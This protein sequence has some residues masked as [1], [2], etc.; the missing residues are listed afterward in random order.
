MAKA[1]IWMV[2]N[3]ISSRDVMEDYPGRLRF[4]LDIAKEN[5]KLLTLA[6]S[7]IRARLPVSDLSIDDKLKCEAILVE[8]ST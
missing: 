4:L 2:R 8:Y 3:I 1:I 7:N 5:P 6:I